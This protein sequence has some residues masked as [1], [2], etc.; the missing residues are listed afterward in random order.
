MKKTKEHREKLSKSMEGHEVS[1][2]VRKKISEKK[3]KKIEEKEYWENHYTTLK[4]AIK[5]AEKRL[6]ER[7]RVFQLDMER[8]VFLISAYS[9]MSGQCFSR[10][11]DWQLDGVEATVEYVE[12]LFRFPDVEVVGVECHEDK[13]RCLIEVGRERVEKRWIYEMDETNILSERMS[14][15]HGVEEEPWVWDDVRPPSIIE[16][17]KDREKGFA[18]MLETNP[19]TEKEK[20]ELNRFEKKVK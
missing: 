12:D 20:M 10:T 1:E 4:E 14:K 6:R 13:V 18:R 3:R 5:K 7:C 19:L 11:K 8:S 9:E 15:R 16:C 17:M 2:E